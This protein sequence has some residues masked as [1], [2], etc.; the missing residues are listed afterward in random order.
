MAVLATRAG[1]EH[2]F[3]LLG[4]VAIAIRCHFNPQTISSIIIYK[5]HLMHE[6]RELKYCQSRK[7]SVGEELE[8]SLVNEVPK[9]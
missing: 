5:N 8:M 9:E 4:H 7:L 2:D 6:R 3:S 1:V